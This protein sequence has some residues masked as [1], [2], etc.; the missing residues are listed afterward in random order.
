MLSSLLMSQQI[1]DPFAICTSVFYS[2]LTIMYWLR[3]YE[4]ALKMLARLAEQCSA[5]LARL[6]PP[7]IKLPSTHP[8]PLPQPDCYQV[9]FY[10]SYLQHEASVGSGSQHIH[11]GYP[12]TPSE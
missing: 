4:T 2:A 12:I 7:S 3:D 11:Q 10:Q 1:E 8:N 6:A 9:S 5:V